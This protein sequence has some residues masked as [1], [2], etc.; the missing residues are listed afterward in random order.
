MIF[1]LKE[2]I[3]IIKITLIKMFLKPKYFVKPFCNNTTY[4]HLFSKEMHTNFQSQKALTVKKIF[5]FALP[6]PVTGLGSCCS[7]GM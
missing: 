2:I 6:G 4:I 1:F 3:K 7:P 5:K